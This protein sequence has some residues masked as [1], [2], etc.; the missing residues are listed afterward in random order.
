MN[1]Q[2]FSSQSQDFQS[3]KLKVDYICFK[4]PSFDDNQERKIADYLFRLR[5][6]S[7]QESGKLANP[8]KESILV[9][10]THEHEVLFVKKGPDWEG[11]T[12]YFSGLNAGRFYF[13]AKQKVI[14]WTI[15][16]SAILSRFDIC[17]NRSYPV[18]ETP[19]VKD[20]FHES[21]KYLDQREITS[22]LHTNQQGYLLTI[23]SRRSNNYSRIYQKEEKPDSLR[24]ELEMKGKILQNYYLLLVQN[25][26]EEFEYQITRNFV[27]YFGRI[28]PLDSIY[29]Q[30][31]SSNLRRF[32]TCYN[33]SLVLKTDYVESG[34]IKYEKTNSI[35]KYN[36]E[37]SLILFLQFLRYIRDGKFHFEREF[38]GSTAYR[39]IYF[40][41]K[42]FLNFQN[43]YRNYHTVDFQK[44][45]KFIYDLQSD[46]L[47]QKF[48]DQY[49]QSLVSVP[50][51][52]FHQSK[53]NKP[54]VA[55]VWIVEELFYYNYPFHFPDLLNQKFQKHEFSVLAYFIQTFSCITIAKRF[56]LKKFFGDYSSLNNRNV[57]KVKE[58]FIK[59]IKLFHEY[60]LIDDKVQI[61]ST[62]SISSLS[63]L[64][65]SNISEGFIIY[66]N[67]TIE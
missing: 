60:N 42:D 66:E 43:P 49:F 24:F 4:F 36:D 55:K 14:N 64:T 34:A 9:S 51:V 38:L 41:V 32:R 67:L 18:S 37:K 46:F 26:F 10:S 44:T 25:S 53:S 54:L 11:T 50:K 22:V 30:W 52:E 65:T 59:Y 27:K 15:F 19:L 31:L 35:L 6:N 40:E 28:L 58:Y 61:L 13:F 45:R 47:L 3:Q 1:L 8:I 16:S 20:F 62:G 7:Y 56:D 33:S 12:L 23:G 48:S 29:T 5:F 63:Q 39:C 21:K 57:R 17:F 2:K